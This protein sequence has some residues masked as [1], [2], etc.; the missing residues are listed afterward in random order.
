MEMATPGQP[1]GPP[2]SAR[3]LL[4]AAR[5]PF[6]GIPELKA[7]YGDLHIGFADVMAGPPEARG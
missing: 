1:P 3:A 2:L 4:A 5:A 7:L 6:T